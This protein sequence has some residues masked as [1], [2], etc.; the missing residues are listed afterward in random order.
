MEN[1]DL[2]LTAQLLNGVFKPKTHVTVEYLEWQY[3]KNPSGSAC[4]G[5]LFEA[6]KQL[7]FD[8]KNFPTLSRRKNHFRYRC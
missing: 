1:L 3:L 7:R 4:I 5:Y 6:N 8:S 2:L